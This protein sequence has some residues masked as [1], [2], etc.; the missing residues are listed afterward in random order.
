M[1]KQLKFGAE[2]RQKLLNGVEILSKAVVTTLGPR[3]RNVAIEK[4]W[5]APQVVHDGVTVAKE[6]D[7]KDPFE[8]IGAQLVKEAASKTNDNAG[9]GT[10]TATLLAKSIITEGMKSLTAGT[11]PMIL[12]RGLQKGLE[13]VVEE[14]QEIKTDVKGT[15][16]IEKIATISA[17]DPEIGEK[18]AEALEKV[19]EDGIVT[20]EESKGWDLDIEYKEGMEFDEG[21][22]SP[23]FVTDSENMVTEIEDPYIILTDQKI[24]AV[25]DILPSLENIIKTSKN[26][27]IIADEIDGEALA[28]LVVNKLRGTFNVLAVKAP[29]F[30][31]RKKEMLQD[32]AILTGG[33]VISEET[34][35]E[36]DSITVEDCGRADKIWA[37]KETTRVIGGQGDDKAIKKRAARL[38]QMAEEAES[39]YDRENLQERLARL[40]GGVAQINVGA[41]T[42][43]ELSEKKERV[44]DAVEATRA[45]VEEGVIPG[46]GSSLLFARRALDKVET[47]NEEEKVGVKILHDALEQPARWLAKN[48]GADDG[49][50][51]A[52]VE[53]ELDE[54]SK[55][56][57]GYDA[58]VGEFVKMTEAG[59]ID[60]LKVTRLALQNAVS[61]GV[62][63]LTTEAMIT[64]LPEEDDESGDGGGG[65]RPGGM[66]GGMSGGMGGGMPGMGGMGM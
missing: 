17:G 20:V 52:K 49:Y 14:L 18:I 45:A 62:M 35:R 23:Y 31:D 19:G 3:G 37:D 40:V 41:A 28:T 33:T 46:G 5:G 9:D 48:A 38:R 30:G 47:I 36:L 32:I 29:G 11:N 21:Y 61:V 24:S 16:D 8:N 53:E 26:I 7:L 43:V 66:G 34:G 39:D 4:S 60:P 25:S 50:V 1:A 54:D 65:G 56:D 64:D 10:T 55:G 12:R 63:A 15:S 58:L 59:I 22:L 2:A 6:I 13:A 42:E 57:Y 44:K 51:V 27:I